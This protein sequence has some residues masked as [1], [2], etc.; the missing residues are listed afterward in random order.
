MAISQGISF[1]TKNFMPVKDGTLLDIL[2]VWIDWEWGESLSFNYV[3]ITK[4]RRMTLLNGHK[5]AEK[6]LLCR[7]AP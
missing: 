5:I 3:P 7:F 2:I 4:V 6:L 1:N